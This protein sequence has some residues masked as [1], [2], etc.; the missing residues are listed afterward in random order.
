MG[1]FY[2]K[3]LG[4]GSFWLGTVPL[5]GI[6]IFAVLFIVFG[7]IP[8][9]FQHPKQYF[10]N[11]SAFEAPTCNQ[12]DWLKNY[13]KDWGDFSSGHATATIDDQG[14][15][16]ITENQVSADTSFYSASDVADE[17]LALP[18]PDMLDFSF[19]KRYRSVIKLDGKV[20]ASGEWSMDDVHKVNDS[21]ND[22]FSQDYVQNLYYAPELHCKKPACDNQRN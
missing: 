6:G 15:L 19:I 2:F 1:V 8:D 5:S 4:G 11:T 16:T 7:I 21:M 13:K 22:V 9:A 3:N 14:L 12:A 20:L 18:F 10:C 17:L